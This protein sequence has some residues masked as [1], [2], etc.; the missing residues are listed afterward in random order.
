[1]TV[2]RK[3]GKNYE[4]DCRVGGRRFRKAVGPSKKFAEFAFGS[5]GPFDIKT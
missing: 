3:R 4:V 5:R 1:M 2:L